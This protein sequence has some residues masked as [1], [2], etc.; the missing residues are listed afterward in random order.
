MFCSSCGGMAS[1]LDPGSR[2]DPVGNVVTHKRAQ[3]G[4]VRWLVFMAVALLVFAPT[5]SRTLD[6]WS[7]GHGVAGHHS[8]HAAHM[9]HPGMPEHP[10]LPDGDVCGYCTLMSHSPLLASGSAFLFLPLPPAPF[11]AALHGASA[12]AP[13]WLDQRS[14]GPPFA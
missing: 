6:A 1:C 12:P 4:V 14:R 13:D 11:S 9:H 3:R 2:V 7:R 10:G 8:G 5:V